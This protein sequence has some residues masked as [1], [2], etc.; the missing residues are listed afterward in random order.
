MRKIIV[1]FAIALL[2][3][4]PIVKAQTDISIL[5]TMSMEILK[6]KDQVSQLELTIKTLNDE[7]TKFIDDTGL[8]L[9]SHVSQ[10]T[11]PL[12]QS[13]PFILFTTTIISGFIVIK[14]MNLIYRK[15]GKAKEN[16]AIGKEESKKLK[17]TRESEEKVRIHKEDTEKLLKEMREESDKTNKNKEKMDS[18]KQEISDKLDE[19]EKIHQES[20]K[21]GI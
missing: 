20:A 3:L 9:A 10:E 18:I 12:K 16:R 1:T 11:D 15:I 8:K 4:M 6:L 7:Q 21:G 19:L 17:E 13:L 2:I 14:G 5:N